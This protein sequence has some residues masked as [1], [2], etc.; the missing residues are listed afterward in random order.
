MCPPVILADEPT[1]DLDDENT[2]LVFG[3]FRKAAEEGAAVLIVSHESDA[4][5]I[6]DAALRMDGGQLS[7]L[8]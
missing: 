8:S 6:A 3:C 1:G 2:Q 4:L 7:A 5:N